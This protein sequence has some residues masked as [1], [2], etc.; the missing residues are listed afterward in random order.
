MTVTTELEAKVDAGKGTPEEV[1]AVATFRRRMQADQD[2]ALKDAMKR[3]RPATNERKTKPSTCKDAA[4]WLKEPDQPDDPLVE[5]LIECQSIVAIVGPSKAAKS[6]LA[7]QMAVEI[8]TGRDTFG[9]KTKRQRVYYVN[10]E[11]SAKQCKKRLRAICRAYGITP[12]ELR[13]WLFIDNLRGEKATWAHCFDEAKRREV[14]VVILDPFYQVFE[15]K[16][17]DETDCKNATEEMKRFVAAGFTLF[18]V[19]HAPKGYSGDRQ[20]VD[21]ISGS[22]VLVRFPENVVAILPH[23]TEKLA[24]VVDCSVLRDYS[25]PD[26]F[27]V[28]FDNGALVMAPDIEPILPTGRGT[29]RVSKSS[30]ERDAEKVKAHNDTFDSMDAALK[31]YLDK[32]GDALPSIGEVTYHLRRRFTKANVAEFLK[33]RRESGA[34]ATCPEMR[35]DERTKTWKTVGPKNGGRILCSTSDRIAAYRKK[36]E[37]F[38][39]T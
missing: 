39:L 12:D 23:A 15:G 36:T 10:V 35:W 20:I 24:R 18:V 27:S 4:D 29:R 13:G 14:Q 34:L 28:K 33:A 37:T 3:Q 1:E 19:F 38:P 2:R 11:V 22:A 25:P 26:P 5:G 17:T 9:R 30:A 8:A 31:S 7:L 6:Y 16:E 21:M 32:R